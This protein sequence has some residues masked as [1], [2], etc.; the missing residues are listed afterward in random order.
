MLACSAEGGQG[1]EDISVDFARVGLGRDDVSALKPSLFRDEFVQ[2]LDLR[3]VIVEDLEER[4]LGSRR[5]FY[6]AET[7]VGAS[8]LEV[9]QVFEEV[10][11]PEAGSL[12][13]GGELGGLEVRVGEAGEGL[14]G[15]AEGR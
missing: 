5:A 14:V 13:D 2:G 12:A 11:G 15:L 7:E 10:L 4:G 8:A 1:V 6:A 3:V 9:G